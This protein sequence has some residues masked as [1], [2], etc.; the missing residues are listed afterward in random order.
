[1]VNNP[2]NSPEG[3]LYAEISRTKPAPQGICVANSAGKA[4]AWALSFDS[5]DS[6]GEF[7]DY[8]ARRFRELPDGTN[9]VV[10]E[11]YM[12]YPSH[13]MPDVADSGTALTIPVRH[14]DKDRCPGRP[15]V[16]RGTLV[17]RVIGRALDGEG[18]PLVDTLRQEQYMEARL[19]IPLVAQRQFV[20]AMRKADGDQFSLPD[21]MVQVLVGPAYLGQ[22]DVNPLGL[23][24]GSENKRR[25]WQFHAREISNGNEQSIRVHVTGHSDVSGHHQQGNLQDDGRHWE[26]DVQLDWQGYFE[27]VGD[28]VTRVTLVAEGHEKLRWGNARLHSTTAPYV[29]HLMAGHPIDIKCGVRYGLFAEPASAEETVDDNSSIAGHFN[30]SGPTPP[31]ARRIRNKL[32]LLQAA[33]QRQQQT[34]QAIAR[35]TQQFGTLMQQQKNVEAERVLDRALQLL[36]TDAR[37]DQRQSDPP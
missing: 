2:P 6:I 7:L 3:R 5:E 12:R 10:T 19:E 27:I 36:G 24:P 23:V 32:Q 37:S 31:V 8:A 30:S 13:K 21:A 4:L 20:E 1:M 22:L 14:A 11:R 34:Q 33:M 28:R 17:G 29:H 25:S 26:H 18:H 15:A 35:L 9:P 16:E